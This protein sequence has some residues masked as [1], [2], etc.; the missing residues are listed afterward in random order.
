MCAEFGV[1]VAVSGETVIRRAPS[2]RRRRGIGVRP[3]S[4]WEGIKK[5]GAAHLE[6]KSGVV[7]VHCRGCDDKRVGM[8]RN[9]KLP[10]STGGRK[11]RA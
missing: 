7:Y 6:S 3:K 2:E 11:G 9:T 1:D 5:R 10:R 4:G 8:A